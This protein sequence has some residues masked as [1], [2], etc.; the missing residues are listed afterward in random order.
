MCH[1]EA[2]DL[3]LWDSRTVHCSSDSLEPPP[4]EAALMRSVGLVCMMPRRLTPPEV[5]EKRKPATWPP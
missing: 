5:L 3:L 4:A 1:L 2:G